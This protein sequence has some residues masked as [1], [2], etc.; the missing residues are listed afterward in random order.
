MR[1]LTPGTAAE[2]ASMRRQEPGSVLAAGTTDLLPRWHSGAP[3]PQSVILLGGIEEMR[4]I[5]QT[6][7]AMEI[8][9]LTTHADIASDGR[10]IEHLPA[11]S[12]AAASIGAPAVRNMGTIGGN[13]ANASPAADLPPPLIAYGASVN[14][15]SDRGTRAVP[16]EGFFLRYQETALMEDEII[17]SVTVPL[18]PDGAASSFQ[19]LG[20]RRAQSIAKVSLAGCASCGSAVEHVRLAAGSMAEVPRRLVEVERVI[21]GRRPDASLVEQACRAAAEAL[22]PIDDVRSTAAYRSHALGVLL[23][24]FL[25][26]IMERCT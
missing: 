19:K 3:R 14:L 16:L 6:D 20:A 15:L 1:I 11:L 21:E 5:R 2:A 7:G 26:L 25:N 8:G 17:L 24:R 4:P 12:A 13:I 23:A 22:R 10:V 9:A 18:P